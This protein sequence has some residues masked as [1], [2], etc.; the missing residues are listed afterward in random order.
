M[1]ISFKCV[2]T[3]T[4]DFVDTTMKALAIT[5]KKFIQ[6]VKKFMSIFLTICITRQ[7]LDLHIRDLSL[8]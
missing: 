6:I 1:L 4:S 2:N 3:N 8:P 7:I 5:C